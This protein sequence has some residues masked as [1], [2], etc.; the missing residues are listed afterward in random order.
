MRDS[1]KVD[2][3]KLYDLVNGNGADRGK[4]L[5]KIGFE[6]LENGR[7]YY[8]HYILFAKNLPEPPI[9]LWKRY[10]D[11]S[12]DLGH[13]LVINSIIKLENLPEEVIEYAKGKEIDTSKKDPLF[14][15]EV[16]ANMMEVKMGLIKLRRFEDKG[17]ISKAN[18]KQ[19][20][21]NNN[22]NNKNVRE[23]KTK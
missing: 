14:E 22:K 11:V 4:E 17:V 9:E 10:I 15:R 5:N 21:R 18:F 13:N 6:L 23:I 7:H 12:A 19:I 3:N 2:V 8:L 16:W 1:Y 20:K